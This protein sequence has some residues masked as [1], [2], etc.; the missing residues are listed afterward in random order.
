MKTIGIGI[1]TRNRS[2]ILDITLNH[3]DVYT[4]DKSK[5]KFFL[6]NDT[7]DQEELNKYNSIYEKYP[8]VEYTNCVE[9]KGIAKAKNECI[10]QLNQCD[11]IFLFDDDCFPKAEGWAEYYIE[12]ST[13]HKIDHMMHLMTIMDFKCQNEYITEYNSCM[14]VMLFFT[15]HALKILGGYDSRFDI[16]GYEHCQMSSRAFKAGLTVTRGSYCTPN[17]TCDF[18][19]SL[20]ID[21]NHRGISPPLVDMN[22]VKYNSSLIGDE[23]KIESFIENNSKYMN[24]FEIYYEP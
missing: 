22:T 20:D 4:P 23:S 17:N 15:N 21:W 6:W 13:T 1:T 12:T 10:K 8:F 11:F 7:D 5:F 18:I 16:Y 24:E 3:F 2:R 19:Y 14:G 9:R